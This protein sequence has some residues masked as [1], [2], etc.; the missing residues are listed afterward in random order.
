MSNST[1][2]ISVKDVI[3]DASMEL[4]DEGQGKVGYPFYRGSAQRA[5][6][7]LCYDAMWDTRI[8]DGP[9]PEGNTFDLELGIIGIDRMWLYNGDNCQLNRTTDLFLRPTMTSGADGTF[10]SNLNY[11][12]Y[13]GFSDGKLYLSPSCDQ[14]TNIHIEYNGLGM[15]KWGDDF[16]IPQWAREAVTDYV[17]LKV[18][19]KLQQD[20]MQ[21]YRA[22]INDKAPETS[23]GNA[24]GSW[25][26]ALA[27]W[28]RMDAKE[29]RDVVVQ[30]TRLG[31]RSGYYGP[32]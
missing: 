21:Y 20:N 7:D 26:K 22:I 23:T 17:I 16:D 14:Y 18:A 1:A 11:L 2:F 12:Y 3:S 24:N 8:W 6:Q 9:K 28:N 4:N 25:C 27:R 10:P 5:L 30:T 29:R 31:R 19:R 32:Y 15:D 13:A